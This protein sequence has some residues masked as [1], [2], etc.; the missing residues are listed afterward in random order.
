MIHTFFR[1]YQCLI[2]T[3]LPTSLG[4]TFSIQRRGLDSIMRL[5]PICGAPRSGPTISCRRDRR[6]ASLAWII[7]FSSSVMAGLDGIVEG[8]L[9][10]GLRQAGSPTATA[11]RC[12]G[13]QSP[14]LTGAKCA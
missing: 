12:S 4:A 7:L 6:T 5:S 1:M 10:G 3:A 11:F 14:M 9:C 2:R 13:L 8:L